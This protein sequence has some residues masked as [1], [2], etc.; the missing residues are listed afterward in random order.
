[1]LRGPLQFL[2]DFLLATQKAEAIAVIKEQ[3]TKLKDNQA[4]LFIEVVSMARVA[5]A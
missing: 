2:F 3:L 5:P 1:M 4:R